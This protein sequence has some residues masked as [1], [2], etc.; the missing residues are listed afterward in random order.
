MNH[1]KANAFRVACTLGLVLAGFSIGAQ[2]EGV[3]DY[4]LALAEDGQTYQVWMR[5]SYT[6][7]PD[8]NLSGQVTIKVPHSA[9][10]QAV[11]VESAVKG[12]NWIEASRINAPIED[13]TSDYISFSFVSPQGDE[14]NGAY[15]WQAG[16]EKLV[17]SFQNAEGCI[18]PIAIMPNDDPFNTS[19]NSSNT[20]PGNHFTNLG[21]GD[22]NKNHFRSV[23]G[24]VL[25]CS[26]GQ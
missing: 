17:F 20:N 4:K 14:V 19:Q 15:K 11:Q 2:A 13:S 9:R 7:L 10:F 23:Y 3:L 22:V 8:I 5:P 24:E 16:K 25:R 21:W 12:S 6:P 18:E 1:K 26:T